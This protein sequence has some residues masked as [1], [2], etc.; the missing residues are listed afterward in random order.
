M[1]TLGEQWLTLWPV[2]G[3]IL[4]LGSSNTEPLL[5]SAYCRAESP[6]RSPNQAP[7]QC[8][9]QSNLVVTCLQYL[10]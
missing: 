4:P 5:G 10:Q 7:S 9:Q 3:E 1:S 6:P 2:P 8:L